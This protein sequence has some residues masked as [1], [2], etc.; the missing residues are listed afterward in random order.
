MTLPSPSKT[1]LQ[2]LGPSIVFVALSLN[3]GE[4][5]LWPDLVAKHGLTIL[6]PI[7]IILLLQYVVNLEIERYTAVTG[8]NTL[9]GMI[10]LQRWIAVL[11]PVSIVVSL[12]WPAWASPAGNMLAYL[13]GLPQYGTW[14]A[15]G[16]M[17]LLMLIWTSPKSYS[18]LESVAK[19]GLTTVFFIVV[20]TVIYNWR[21]EAASE[22]AKGML[23][24]GYVPENINRFTFVSALA[25]GGVAGVLNLVQSDWVASKGYAAAG[26]KN[27]E[28]INWED[29]KTQQNWQQWWKLLRKEHTVLFYVGNLVGISLL[30]ILSF[31]ILTGTGVSGFRLLTSEVEILN[32]IFP[33]LGILFGGAVVLLFTMAQ[34]TILDAQGRLLKKCTNTKLSSNQL[35]QIVGGIGILILLITAFNPNFNQPSSLLQISASLSAAVMAIYPP[36]LLYLN[37]KLPKNT[38]ASTFNKILVVAC[39]VFYGIIVIWSLLG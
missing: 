15:I 2:L 8:K 18:I 10:Q 37:S 7:P 25:Y 3:G 19:I 26:V 6:W 39:S 23:N 32:K 20:G 28:N 13:V 5:L 30:A 35:S 1:L 24:I 11:F 31:L 17:L 14:F 22:F 12:V 38:Q 4:M 16:V 36:I 34:M 29:P 21:W 9:T 33:Y 27:P